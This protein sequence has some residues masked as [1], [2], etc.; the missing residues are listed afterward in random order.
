M[1]ESVDDIPLDRI[2]P[3]P[4]QPRRRFDTGALN[5]LARS[6]EAHNVIQPIVV[7]P[8]KAADCDYELLSGERRWR[9][10]QLAGWDT[11][12][13]LVRNVSDQQALEVALVENI[14]RENLSPIEEAEAIARLIA[15]F[16]LRHEDAAARVAKS[17]VHITNLLRLLNLPPAV[18]D[19]IH[20]GEL[21]VGHAK[22]LCGVE[23]PVKQMWLARESVKRRLRIDQLEERVRAWRGKKAAARAPAVD[24]NLQDLVEHLS[25][26]AG[27][28]VSLEHRKDGSG[29]VVITYYSPEELE[30]FLSH[31]PRSDD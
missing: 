8:V 21:T 24:P 11:I 14:Q 6:L 17:R 7:R 1:K 31:F 13:A 15:E 22:V 26:A 4:Y 29:K 18:Q 10:A 27:L 30:G 2:R 19:F 25:E 3:S 23:D 9:A 20:D 28:P 5:E 12:R 16:E